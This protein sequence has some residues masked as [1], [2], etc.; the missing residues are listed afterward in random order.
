MNL[1]MSTEKQKNMWKNKKHPMKDRNHTIDYNKR[2]S[3]EDNLVILCK[4][5]H[6]I[7][8][9]NREKWIKFFRRKNE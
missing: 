9:W 8:Q 2:N 3:K 5:C 6:N 7:T 4:S 1:K